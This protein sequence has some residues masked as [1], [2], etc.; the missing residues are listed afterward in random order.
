MFVYM[1][2]SKHFYCLLPIFY[3]ILIEGKLNVISI[4]KRRLKPQNVQHFSASAF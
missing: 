1:Y 2:I 3:S 4:E